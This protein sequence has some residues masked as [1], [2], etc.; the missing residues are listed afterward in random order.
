MHRSDTIA[1]AKLAQAS[2]GSTLA[3]PFN[4]KDSRDSSRRSHLSL[5]GHKHHHH[6]HHHGHHRHSSRSSKHG[7]DDKET[8]SAVLP[9]TRP[10]YP[11]GARSGNNA[12]GSTNGGSGI[13][14]DAR[15]LVSPSV[16]AEYDASVRRV[17]SRVVRPEDVV[18]E[19]ARRKRREEQLRNALHALSEQSMATTRRLDDTYYSILEKLSGLHSTID[20]LQELSTLTK[21]LGDEF[22]SDADELVDE[23]SNSLDSI[24]DFESQARLLEEFEA[25][26][27][28]GKEKAARLNERLEAARKR[29]EQREKLEEEWRTSVNRRLRIFWSVLGGFVALILV[30]YLVYGIRTQKQ[31]DPASRHALSLANHS[32][33]LEDVVPPPVREVLESVHSSSTST[34][35]PSPPTSNSASHDERLHV[36]D[37][38]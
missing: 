6:S 26:I 29:V 27:V 2:R 24:G 22:A 20:G 10:S 23:M 3:A 21:K 9:T 16:V 14:N 4:L 28:A 38:L 11:D 17:S 12:S 13:G 34:S 8:K 19:R 35:I 1:I 25:R 33:V 7:G 37:E 15:D 36:F 32:I 31:L 5:P 30:A 18:K